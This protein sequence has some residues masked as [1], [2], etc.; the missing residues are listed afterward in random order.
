MCGRAI[1]PNESR[2]P[3][4]SCTS[5]SSGLRLPRWTRARTFSAARVEHRHDLRLQQ[6]VDRPAFDLVLVGQVG[7]L[8][9]GAD[10]PAVVLL[11]ALDP[12]AVQNAQVQPAVDADLHAAGARRLQRPARVIQ[13]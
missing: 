2:T 7:V 10:G 4:K 8:L 6:V 5:T 12:P 3:W 11:V 9:A 13:P 1:S